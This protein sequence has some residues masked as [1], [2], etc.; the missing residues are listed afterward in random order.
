MLCDIANI[1]LERKSHFL[2]A[3]QLRSKNN[4]LGKISRPKHWG[5]KLRAQQS[6][7]QELEVLK[8]PIFNLNLLYIYVVDIA[9]L[10][11]YFFSRNTLVIRAWQ[12]S[13]ARSDWLLF[14]EKEGDGLYKWFR[15]TSLQFYQ[16]SKWDFQREKCLTLSEKWTMFTV[17]PSNSGYMR[18]VGRQLSSHRCSRLYLGH[19]LRNL[20]ALP[21]IRVH[22]ELDGRTLD[23]VHSFE[24]I[25]QF[26]LN[27]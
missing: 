23:I 14:Y 2:D 18:I 19:L 21:T 27:G 9:V 6:T 15:L 12:H 11:W 13:N 24:K 20:R 25:T 3:Y 10:S 4:H 22:P 16:Y 5:A 8:V 7:P 26:W 1:S 17:R